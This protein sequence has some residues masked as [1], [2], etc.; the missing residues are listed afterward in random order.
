[1]AAFLARFANDAEVGTDLIIPGW[2]Q[3]LV[4]DITEFYA[5][6]LALISHIPDVNVLRP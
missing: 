3:E 6:D 4:D 1:M 5:E 2:T